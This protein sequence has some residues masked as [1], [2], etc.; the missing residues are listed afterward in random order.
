[1]MKIPSRESLP[2]SSS[3]TMMVCAEL[4]IPAILI[5]Q[6]SFFHS[7]HT[8]IIK[9]YRY[10]TCMFFNYNRCWGGSTDWF[11]G[12][13]A[14]QPSISLPKPPVVSPFLEREVWITPPYTHRKTWSRHKSGTSSTS[15][16][17]QRTTSTS[18]AGG[19]SQQIQG[20]TDKTRVGTCPE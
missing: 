13:S 16:P 5:R 7:D 2:N 8:L 17:I 18:G 3:V 14:S 19:I 6:K 10:C 4:Y 15:E 12:W 9:Y 1:M 11:F 20:K